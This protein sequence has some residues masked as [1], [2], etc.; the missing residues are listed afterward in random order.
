MRK[1]C[2]GIMTPSRH[3]NLFFLRE[4]ASPHPFTS[5]Q[6]IFNNTLWSLY[7]HT[8]HRKSGRQPCREPIWFSQPT[9][10]EPGVRCTRLGAKLWATSRGTNSGSL[11]ANTPNSGSQAKC[12][13]PSDSGKKGW[14]WELGLEE[15]L[16]S[17]VYTAG[18]LN[19]LVQAR[20]VEWT[21]SHLLFP[22]FNDSLQG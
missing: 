18:F 22:S 7:E 17:S 19:P 8:A 20:S 12:G 11:E 6:Y 4:L 10:R 2:L 14:S 13:G 21:C 1:D 5:Q 3:L 15:G 16:D 9:S